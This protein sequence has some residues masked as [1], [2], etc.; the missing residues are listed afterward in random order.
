MTPVDHR[1]AY[2]PISPWPFT[3]YFRERR[4]IVA[5]LMSDQLSL[6]SQSNLL[7]SSV[8]LIQ[9][10]VSSYRHLSSRPWFLSSTKLASRARV[11]VLRSLS[12]PAGTRSSPELGIY[13]PPVHASTRPT[14][15]LSSALAEFL[16]A[17]A[18]KA[19]SRHSRP[20]RED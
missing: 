13:R 10:V 14:G 1:K 16:P 8:I 20:R 4:C 19:P 6:L 17:R 5:R 3:Q 2:S 7:V 18:K 12:R 9:S 11:R 15:H